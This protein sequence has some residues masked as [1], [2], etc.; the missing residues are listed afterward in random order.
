MRKTLVASGF[1]FI[2]LF[3]TTYWNFGQNIQIT[4]TITIKVDKPE[5][6]RGTPISLCAIEGK[7]FLFTDSHSVTIPVF[8]K[9]NG[10]LE[11]KEELGP[12]FGKERF[13][14]PL[15]CFYNQ[16]IGMLGVFDY[17]QRRILIFDRIAKNG[18]KDN[19]KVD[20]TFLKS[21]SCPRGGYDFDFEEKEKQLVISGYMT[22]TNDKPF[23]LYSIDIRSGEI[24]CLLPSYEKY[25]LT[26]YEE[27]NR[28]Y[29]RYQVL[30]AVG[31]LAFI[32]IQ[33]NNLFFVWE[34]SLRIIKVDLLSRKN[35]VLVEP[36]SEK[37]PHYVKPDGERLGKF[38]KNGDFKT[39]WEEQKKVSYVRNIFISSR[40]VFLV[41]E[42]GKNDKNSNSL[43][44]LQ[45]YTK[46]GIFLSDALIP[47]GFG[48]QM[49][50]D[51]KT[52]ELYLLSEKSG[53]DNV[54]LLVLRYKI[55]I[56]G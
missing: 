6:F 8:K 56:D 13:N 50:F 20:F 46:E 43:L 41:Y 49:W 29:R 52:C 31:S 18:R 55:D 35:K 27:Y 19:E 32:D 54:E 51:K 17:G 47:G 22:D 42:T 33:G 23:D 30:P 21:I 2:F 53:S 38:Y 11:F 26:T 7:Y 44:R 14:G 36:A 5:K 40:H 25:G 28:L 24:H 34:G 4:E 15:Y 9:N 45:T 39:T 37:F 3:L 16:N 10:S 12:N 48:R 1:L